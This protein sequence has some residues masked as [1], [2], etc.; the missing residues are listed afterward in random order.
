MDLISFPGREWNED[1]LFYGEY[2]WFVLDGATSLVPNKYSK[3][4]TDAKWYSKTFGKYLE[5][6]LLNF[7]KPI[8]EIVKD[9]I[10]KIIAEYK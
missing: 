10:H 5:K 4:E 8:S 9:G 1:Y 2:V 6:A 7:D 3:E